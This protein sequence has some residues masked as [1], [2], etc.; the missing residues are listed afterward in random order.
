M[1]W[2]FPPNEGVKLNK[3]GASKGNPDYAGA[4]GLIRDSS[5]G[6]GALHIG[7]AS[8]LQFKQSYGLFKQ[9]WNWCGRG[10]AIGPSFRGCPF[11]I[12]CLFDFHM[13][14]KRYTLNELSSPRK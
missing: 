10:V 8:V 11:R 13:R 7:W 4:G 9:G 1:F 6:L 12:C 14:F 2:P 5:G 3:D